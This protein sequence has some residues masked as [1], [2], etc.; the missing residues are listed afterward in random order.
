MERIKLFGSTADK[1]TKDNSKARNVA[2]AVGA[3]G[4]GLGSGLITQAAVEGWDNQV[5]EGLKRSRIRIKKSHKELLEDTKKIYGQEPKQAAIDILKSSEK[6]ALEN[7]KKKGIRIRKITRPASK[8]AKST[9]GKVA[10][11]GI[12]TA[13][14]G[15][16]V[17]RSSK[18]HDK[19]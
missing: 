1:A 6:E 13:I 19:E 12:P 3:A 16:Q 18:K 4:I 7:L 9:A 11:I 2:R 8:F 10:L 15:G 14:I 17:Y 5:K